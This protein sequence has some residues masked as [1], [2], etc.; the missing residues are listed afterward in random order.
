[1]QQSSVRKLRKTLS[2][3]FSTSGLMLFFFASVFVYG[4]HGKQLN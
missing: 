1:M 4:V 3:F 2:M